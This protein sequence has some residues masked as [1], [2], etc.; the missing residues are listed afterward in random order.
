MHKSLLASLCAALLLGACATSS[1]EISKEQKIG[2]LYLRAGNADVMANNFTSALQNLQKAEKYVPKNEDL[3]I[4]FGLAYFGKKNF[5]RSEE[6]FQKALALN[7]KNNFARNDLGAIYLEQAKYAQ[8]QRE[9]ETVLKD[10]AFSDQYKTLYNLGVIQYKLGKYISAEDYFTR[11]VKESSSFCLGWTKL[12]D[13]Q[14]QLGKREEAIASLRSASSGLCYNN[15]E[16]HYHL[17]LLLTQE[18][19]T[20]KA[21]D[22]FE[23]IT[24]R[25]PNSP[26][27]KLSEDKLRA[28]AHK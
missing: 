27:A 14:M 17:G 9:F 16:A 19:Q 25:F 5:K 10:L 26:W 1:Q 2:E 22:K 24:Q 4:A 23:E 20:D 28:L 18:R 8:A 15:T 21:R 3:W 11:S 6:S 13:A 7:P 12:S